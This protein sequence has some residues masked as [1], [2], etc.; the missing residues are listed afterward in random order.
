M[1]DRQGRPFC[2]AH[3]L[4][5]EKQDGPGNPIWS[6]I[7]QRANPVVHWPHE[8]ATKLDQRIKDD[9][10]PPHEPKVTGLAISLSVRKSLASKNSGPFPQRWGL[11]RKGACRSS[12]E[13]IGSNV[14]RHTKNSQS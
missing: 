6:V 11:L 7:D 5:S 2:H 4:A 14:C 3:M 10:K 13:K 8:E 9:P 1:A 12:G